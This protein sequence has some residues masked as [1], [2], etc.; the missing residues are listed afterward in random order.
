MDLKMRS[1]KRYGSLHF[2]P[3]PP[4]T[5]FILFIF[6]MQVR[7]ITALA[8]AA[9]AEAAAPYGIGM[10]FIL[11]KTAKFLMIHIGN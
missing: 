7:T 5:L 10:F 2:P 8:I 6:V 9:L 11:K 1:N 4:I 3:V